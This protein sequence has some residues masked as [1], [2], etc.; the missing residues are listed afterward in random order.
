MFNVSATRLTLYA[1]ITAIE[2]DI[3][4]FIRENTS[5]QNKDI[6]FDQNLIEKLKSRAKRHDNFEENLN[7]LIEYL[8]FGDCI[9]ILNK[10]KPIFPKSFIKILEKY[11]AELEKIV[12]IRNRVMHSRPLEYSDFPIVS[13]FMDQLKNDLINWVS[14]IDIKNKIA[15]DPSTIFG[16]KIPEFIDVTDDKILNNLP[17]AEFDDTGFIGRENDL[18]MI[19]KKILGNYPVISIIGDGG[20]GKTALTLKCLYD[21]IDDANQPFDAI[22]WISLK[23]KTLNN[24]EFVNIK[25]TISSTLELYQE[26]KNVLIGKSITINDSDKI[27]EEIL[28]YMKEFRTLLVLD[29]LESIN[30]ELLREFLFNIPSGSKIL[31]TSR[32]GIGEFEARHVLEGL[33]KKERIFYMRRLAQNHKLYDILKMQDVQLNSICEKLHSNPLAIKWLIANLMKGAPIESILTN[34][35]NL[36]FYCMSNVY[37]KLSKNAKIVLDTLLIYNKDCSDAEL[38]YLLELDSI[39]HRKALNELMATNMIRMRTIVTNNERKSLFSI[40]DFAKEYLYQH[41]RP[42]NDAFKIVKK[43]IKDLKLL[44]QNLSIDVEINPFNPK[45]ITYKANTDQ[46]IAAYNLKQALGYSAKQEYE[47]AFSLIDRSKDIDPNYFEVYKISAF[48]HASHGDYFKADNEYQTA[49]QCNPDHASLLFLYAGFKMRYLE[50]FEEALEL[51]VQAEEIDTEN[52]DIKIQKARLYMFLGKFKDS[53]E[54]FNNLR[55]LLRDMQ[56]KEKVITLDL[57]A[58]NLRRWS[59]ILINENREN[60]ATDILKKAVEI[61]EDYPAHDRKMLKTLTKIIKTLSYMCEND[62]NAT[63]LLKNI[64]QKFS[65]ELRNSN[66]HKDVKQAIEAI[67]P[68][69]SIYNRKQFEPFLQESVRD[70]AKKV[71]NENQGYIVSKAKSFAFI[72]NNKFENGLFAF[73]KEFVGEFVDLNIGDKVEFKVGES[74][75]GICAIQ[76]EKIEKFTT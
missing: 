40:T 6:L 13:D 68:Q 32:I 31:T 45:S 70:L 69:L 49:I 22:I 74:E 26:I 42:S 35:E 62:N 12:P 4:E 9:S 28:E 73:W 66:N 67:Y 58:E 57:S 54:I 17:A 47:K 14:T 43:R 34:T 63:N 10:F 11:S 30:S 24:G 21:I 52:I 27:V 60:E 33:N 15:K 29:N 1:F 25:N 39:L 61:L 2:T 55:V 3:R 76:V 16:I 7:N 23:T 50:D 72:S 37:D 48:I 51:T 46:I 75:K 8:D 36:T 38:A 5:G 59:E 64:L 53:E 65:N 20:I 71:L 18:N 56:G 41:C 44:G 19:K